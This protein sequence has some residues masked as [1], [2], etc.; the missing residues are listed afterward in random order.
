MEAEREEVAHAPL[1][2]VWLP[3]TPEAAQAYP[4]NLD[5]SLED[6]SKLRRE[7][8][9]ELHGQRVPS[10]S[11]DVPHAAFLGASRRV[12]DHVTNHL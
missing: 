1:E 11:E 5:L 4:L 8:H 2:L 12:L 7:C 3:S 10:P 6:N 9:S